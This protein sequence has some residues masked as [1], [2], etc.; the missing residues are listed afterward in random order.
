MLK[1]ILLAPLALLAF[2]AASPFWL[3]GSAIGLVPAAFIL[4]WD[5]LTTTVGGAVYATSGSM[6]SNKKTGG[7]SKFHDWLKAQLATEGVTVHQLAVKWG[8][9]RQNIDNYKR[10]GDPSYPMM[11]KIAKAAGIDPRIWF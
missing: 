9:E 6:S 3:T 5:G 4:M 1:F 11:M 2:V 7:D 8:I 10:G